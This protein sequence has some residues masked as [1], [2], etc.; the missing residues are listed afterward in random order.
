MG[1]QALFGAR[2][3]ELDRLRSE[4]T[5]LATQFAAANEVLSAIGRSV[6]EPDKVLIIVVES[7][8]RL[9]IL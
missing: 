9:C 2:E 3:T 7:A 6:G 1:G 5:S 4:L 8:C